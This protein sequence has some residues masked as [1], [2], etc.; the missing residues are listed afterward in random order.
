[1]IPKT[2]LGKWAGGLSAVF[3]VF[4]IALILGRN[5][6]GLRPGTPLIVTIGLCAM[7]AGIATFV[8]AIVSLMRFKD[9]SLVVILATIF[10]FLAILMIIF[11]L[12]GGVIWRLNH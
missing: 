7:F 4:F 6:A 5:L 3:L 10:G 9:R 11:G 1:M 2:T 12:V 8:T